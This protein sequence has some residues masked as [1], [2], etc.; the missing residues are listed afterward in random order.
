MSTI[1]DLDTGRFLGVV[2]ASISI[3]QQARLLVSA[4]TWRLGVHVV[5]IDPSDAFRKAIRLR[6]PRSTVSIDHFHV[7][8]LA[9]Q[10]LSKDR[11]RLS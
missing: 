4:V 9:N 7:A 6:V 11:Q 3:G 5:A 2:D 8:A 1:V 10:A